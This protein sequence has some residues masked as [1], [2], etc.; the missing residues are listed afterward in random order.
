VRKFYPASLPTAFAYFACRSI[1][2][3]LA[4]FELAR[5]H[6][7]CL[8]LR[9][10]AMGVKGQPAAYGEAALVREYVDKLDQQDSLDD[11]PAFILNGGSQAGSQRTAS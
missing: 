3:K 11:R 1:A 2:P 4:R 7:V 5:L 10:F 9:D 8:A 6:A